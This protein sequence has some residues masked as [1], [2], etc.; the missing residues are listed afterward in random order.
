MPVW[1]RTAY[2]VAML[3]AALCVGLAGCTKDD[4]KDADKKAAD[5]K[6]GDKKD[7]EPASNPKVTKE[8]FAK[9]KFDMT[10]KDVT[11]ILGTPTET[12]DTKGGKKLTWKSG[13]NKIDVDFADG[14]VM[15]I[16]DQFVTPSK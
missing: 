3:A 11:D 10:E 15:G 5:K 7:G 14:K 6:D 9:V 13:N 1:L 2:V 16:Q 8:N 12:K 4:K